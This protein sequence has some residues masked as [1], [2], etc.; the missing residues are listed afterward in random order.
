MIPPRV[1][2]GKKRK[3]GKIKKSCKNGTLRGRRNKN[4]LQREEMLQGYEFS[5]TKAASTVFVIM[6]YMYTIFRLD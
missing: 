2:L 6:I 1:F 4:L 3:E 5:G